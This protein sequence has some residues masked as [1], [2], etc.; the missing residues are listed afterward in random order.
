MLHNQP[1]SKRQYVNRF[2]AKH[3][4]EAAFTALLFIFSLNNLVA[5][6][7][8]SV[9]EDIIAF[10][11]ATVIDGTGAEPERNATILT[12]GDKITCVGSCEIPTNAR[13]INANGKYI[14]PGLVDLHVHYALSGWIDS[15]PGIFG[16]DVSDKYPYEEVYEN[17]KTNPDRFHRS[18][19][20]SGVTT[21]FEPGGFPWGYQVEQQTIKATNAPRYMTAGPILTS[22][23]T[24]IPHPLG[25]DMSVYME[26]KETVRNAVRMLHWNENNWVKV[27]RP[28]LI[29]DRSRRLNLLDAIRE[30]ANKA[31][32]S[33]IANTPNLESAKDLLRAGTSLFVYPVE[34]TLVDQEFLRLA[35]ENNLVYTPAFEAGAGRKEIRA[36][37]FDENRLPLDCVD[38][39]TRNKAFYTD[40]LPSS[41]GDAT[42]IPDQAEEIRNIREENFKRIHE[43]GITIAVGSSSGA[44]LTFHG[45]ATVHEMKAMSNA[46]LSPMETIVAATKNGAE[47][48]G[49]TDTGTLEVGKRANLLILNANPLQNISNIRQIE[50]VVKNGKIWQR[51]LLEYE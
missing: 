37:N 41:S 4:L 23:E 47:A 46:G 51:D 24:I 8:G 35:R 31:D 44:P 27:H 38:P 33:L 5:Q 6:P 45:P 12:K 39:Q 18:H 40:S 26:D 9:D 19:L 22:F 48:L 28:D 10:T 15:I 32:L 14:M 29:E 25:D 13:V 16:V 1:E 50:Y 2:I 30:E 7:Q 42:I 20:C 3:S 49:L 34:D 17:L 11:G 36:R 21:V 43:A